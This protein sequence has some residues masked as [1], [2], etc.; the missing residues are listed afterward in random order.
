MSSGD[1]FFLSLPECLYCCGHS[2]GGMGDLT[3]LFPGPDQITGFAA[4]LLCKLRVAVLS[5]TRLQK[6]ALSYRGFF[7]F[8]F[9]VLTWMQSENTVRQRELLFVM[10]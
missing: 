1:F 4:R 2:R 10:N 3:H 5:N 8:L 9:M 6:E 7:F